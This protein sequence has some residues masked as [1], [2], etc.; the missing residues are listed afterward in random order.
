MCCLKTNWVNLNMN[1]TEK[2][3]GAWKTKITK[4]DTPKETNM[5]LQRT[6]RQHHWNLQW[7]RKFNENAFAVEIFQSSRKQGTFRKPIFR[8]KIRLVNTV[9]ACKGSQ[10]GRSSSNAK[11]TCSSEKV[12][13]PQQKQRNQSKRY[14]EKGYNTISTENLRLPQ[15]QTRIPRKKITL[16]RLRIF[17]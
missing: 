6:L 8:K 14:Q 4:H 10:K 9:R 16:K 11:Q 12:S 17:K 15:M 13:D 7:R 3:S 2:H 1:I 5:D